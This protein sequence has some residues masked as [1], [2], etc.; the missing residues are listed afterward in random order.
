MTTSLHFIVKTFQELD[1]AELYALLQLRAEV[2]VVEQ[3]CVYQD[4][5]G[6]DQSAFHVLGFKENRL[7]AYARIFKPGAYF[8]KTSIGRVLVAVNER[9]Q[10]YGH[11]LMDFCI[12][13]IEDEWQSASIEISA[14]LYLKDFYEQHQFLQVSDMYL[15]DEIPHIRMIRSKD[16]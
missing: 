3:N 8:E 4:I 6:K 12:S 7:I 2:F 10:A 11:Q 9:K 5:D 13:W 15:E 14:Q 16:D 1:T